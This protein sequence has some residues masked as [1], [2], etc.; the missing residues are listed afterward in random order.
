MITSKTKL[1]I[2]KILCQFKDIIFLRSSVELDCEC[3]TNQKIK[4][5]SMIINARIKHRFCPF[6]KD[7]K[8][9]LVSS[10]NRIGIVIK[11]R[12]LK[13]R[14][15]NIFTHSQNFFSI[16]TE[17]VWKV[18]K[19]FYKLIIDDYWVFMMY[20]LLNIYHHLSQPW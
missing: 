13:N 7:A 20:N 5:I 18:N 14:K 8:P 4:E 10:R 3:S 11:N 9:K 16:L 6:S 12:K 2:L 17:H 19:T 15:F 1:H